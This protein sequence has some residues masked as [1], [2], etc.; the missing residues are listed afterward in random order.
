[1]TIGGDNEKTNKETYLRYFDAVE[2]AFD[3]WDSTS[4]RNRGDDGD[5]KGG[6]ADQ[7]RVEDHPDE[8]RERKGIC[9]G[10]PGRIRKNTLSQNSS[11]SLRKN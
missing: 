4:C 8:Q 6:E 11:S 3:L 1:M 2:V 5:Q 7:Q 10:E 9:V